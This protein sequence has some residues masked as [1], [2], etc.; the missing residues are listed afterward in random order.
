MDFHTIL[1]D[2]PPTPTSQQLAPARDATLFPIDEEVNQQQ[3]KP[4]VAITSSEKDEI[5]EQQPSRDHC[6]RRRPDEEDI[7]RLVKMP[8]DL[9]GK[10]VTPFLKQH[11]P[12]IYAPIGKTSQQDIELSASPRKKDP[13]SKYCY[14]HRPDSK[15]RRA[16]D[17][18]KMG[19]IQSVSLSPESS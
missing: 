18:T 8:S 5:P 9:V 15:C 19:F 4:D 12:A 6:D 1:D 13:N 2:Y 11:I 7:S 10:T 16:A 17:E 3:R 14:R